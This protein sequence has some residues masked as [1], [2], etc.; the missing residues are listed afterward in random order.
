MPLADITAIANLALSHLGEP[1]LDSDSDQ[2]TTADAVRLHLPQCTETVL[3]SHVWSFATKTAYLTQA[4]AF[5]P[6]AGNVGFYGTVGDFFEPSEDDP[7]TPF[8]SQ[9]QSLFLLPEDCLR[10]LKLATYDIDIPRNRWEIQG[11]YL[12]LEEKDAAEPLCH[13]IGAEPPV[14]TWPTTF[15]DAVAFLLAARLAP[16]LT[17]DQRL[18]ADFLQKHEMALGKARSKDARETRSKENHGP[19]HLAARSALVRSRYGATPPPY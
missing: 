15:T 12:L 10:V 14:P 5:L 3:E 2:G 1:F 8:V 11:R 19:R 16:L 9:F 4:G 18:A 7:E 13:Y 6:T 17:Q